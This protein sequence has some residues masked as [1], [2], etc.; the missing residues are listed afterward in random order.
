MVFPVLSTKRLIL[1]QLDDSD[2]PEIY[3]LRSDDNVNKYISRAKETNIDGAKGFIK[4]INEGIR[5]T[6]S[7]YWAIC[8]VDKKQLSG[9]ICLWN[10]SEDNTVGE[11]GFELRPT[12]QGKGIMNEALGSVINY[13]FTELGMRTILAYVHKDNTPS[14]QLLEKNNFIKDDLRKDDENLNNIV[15]LLKNPGFSR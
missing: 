5:E 7:L 15:Y 6:K 4:K 14:L 13:G 12:Y 2:Y 3:L 1:R 10:F 8:L 11:I 9:T